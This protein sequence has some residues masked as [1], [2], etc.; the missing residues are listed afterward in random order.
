MMQVFVVMFISYLACRPKCPSAAELPTPATP[1]TRRNV[2]TRAVISFMLYKPNVTTT[3]YV[4]R[5]RIVLIVRMH[6][7]FYLRIINRPNDRTA[8]IQRHFISCHDLRG[9]VFGG[10]EGIMPYPLWLNLFD[11]FRG[12]VA[13][14]HGR[15]A[16]PVGHATGP[17]TRVFNIGLF[18]DQ[19]CLMFFV[20]QTARRPINSTEKR[21]VEICYSAYDLDEDAQTS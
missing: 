20:I 7:R 15:L 9:D 18:V 1:H 10:G 13:A 6:S 5:S 2:S 4:T 21:L 16:L 19:Y 8:W 11:F 12:F 17:L 3:R 14:P